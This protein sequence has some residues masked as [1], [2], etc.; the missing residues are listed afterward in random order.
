[1]LA[2]VPAGTG[3]PLVRLRTKTSADSLQDEY[4]TPPRTVSKLRSPKA[5]SVSGQTPSTEPTASP[6]PGSTQQFRG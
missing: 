5:P 6:T 1:M 2:I 4:V 3:C